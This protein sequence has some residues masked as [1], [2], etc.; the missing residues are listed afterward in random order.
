MR[1]VAIWP[2]WRSSWA[3]AFGIE[4]YTRT[5]EALDRIT[6]GF[7]RLALQRLGLD[8]RPGGLLTFGALADELGVADRHRRLLR[9]LLA[10]LTEAEQLEQVGP[11]WR[12]LPAPDT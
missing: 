12:M 3:H 1:C 6:A 4:V 11:A 9:R 5:A 8:W 2:R 10:I 7:I